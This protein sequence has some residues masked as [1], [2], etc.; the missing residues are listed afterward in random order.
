MITWAVAP[1]A[2]GFGAVALSL[3]R[4]CCPRW[5]TAHSEQAEWTHRAR[6]AALWTDT[7]VDIWRCQQ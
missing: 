3:A 2:Q 7:T 5:H 1:R 6:P 4:M